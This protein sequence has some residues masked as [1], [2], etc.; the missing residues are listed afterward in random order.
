MMQLQTEKPYYNP[1]EY[2]ALEEA[3]EDKNEYGI[4]LLP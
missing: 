3:A 2:L 4:T 1:E